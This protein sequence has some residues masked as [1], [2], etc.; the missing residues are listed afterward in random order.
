MKTVIQS[1]LGTY[2]PVTYSQAGV[3]IIPAGLAGCDW[4]YIFGAILFTLTVYLTLRL[5]GVLFKS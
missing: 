1:I 5:I 3:D 4:E 2:E